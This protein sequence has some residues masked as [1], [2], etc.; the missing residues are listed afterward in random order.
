MKAEHRKELQTNALA[1]RMGRV[2]QRMKTR[3]NRS[4]VLTWILVGVLAVAV[5][6]FLWSR[7]RSRA[8]LAEAWF[9]VD[10]EAQNVLRSLAQS[11][12]QVLSEL[13]NERQTNPVIATRFQGA[14]FC[15]W[16]F[17]VKSLTKGNPIQAVT[18]VKVAQEQ[19]RNLALADEVKE[20]PVLAPEALYAIAVA[21]ETLAISTPNQEKHLEQA[22]KDYRAV[23]DRFPKSAHGKEA[24]KRLAE[25]EDR[26][27]RRQI[28]A[29]YTQLAQRTH[30]D[31]FEQL[32]R[33]QGQQPRQQPKKK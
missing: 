30:Y 20:D 9:S 17:G 29:F 8:T 2:I 22:A 13:E 31:I 12:L 24:K 32:H 19:Y 23:A 3:P 27:Q 16:E 11:K 25:L 26:D 5:A 14:W 10:E 7:S 15:L 6:I 1:D 4:S 21:E 28:A 18:Y 33:Q